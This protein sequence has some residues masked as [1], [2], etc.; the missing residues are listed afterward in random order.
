MRPCSINNRTVVRWFISAFGVNEKTFD[1][2]STTVV[3]RNEAYSLLG[4][5]GGDLALADL[6]KI[7]SPNLWRR[8]SLRVE[9]EFNVPVSVGLVSPSISPS[10]SPEEP[11]GAQEE[12]A[13]KWARS[14]SI[15]VGDSILVD[16]Q[17]RAKVQSVDDGGLRVKYEYSG[18]EVSLEFARCKKLAR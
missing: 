2:H 14:D 3:R 1:V 7:T 17:I 16:E 6:K 12:K 18:A 11:E 9:E 4:G 5:G 13:V 10:A 15:R 8:Y